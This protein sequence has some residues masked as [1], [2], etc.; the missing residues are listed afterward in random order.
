[1]AQR[2]WLVMV[3]AGTLGVASCP[4]A[5]PECKSAADCGAT[6]AGTCDSCPATASQYCEGGV[7][8]SAP[9]K[10]LNLTADVTARNQAILSMRFVVVSFVSTA[11]L[12][13]CSGQPNCAAAAIT[14]DDLQNV[15]WSDARFN[16]ALSGARN[17]SGGG[18][19]FL[20]VPI[21][22]VPGEKHLIAMEGRSGT[23]G[24]GNKVSQACLLINQAKMSITLSPI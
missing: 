9:D 14:C 15:E 22:Q 3:L 2:L 6:T 11:E 8:R 23:L 20:D 1:M 5:G 18:D 7:C 24:A 16:V 10:S 17:L 19:T 13:Q 12:S 21:G 4:G